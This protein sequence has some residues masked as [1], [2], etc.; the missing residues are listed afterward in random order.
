VGKP[1]TAS[2]WEQKTHFSLVVP[3]GS[4]PLDRFGVS[5]PQ[6][7]GGQNTEPSG[8]GRWGGGG[9]G[10]GTLHRVKRGAPGP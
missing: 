1:G 8:G 6:G 2:D 4:R 10:G 9:G 5:A 3:E 7:V